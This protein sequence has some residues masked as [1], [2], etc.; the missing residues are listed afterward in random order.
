[1][2]RREEKLLFPVFFVGKR[3]KICYNKR[4][5]NMNGKKEEFLSALFGERTVEKTAGLSFSAA[6]ILPTLLALLFVIVGGAF[7][8]FQE[9]YETADWYQYFN[10]LLPQIGYAL[11]AALFFSLSRLPVKEITGNPSLKYFLIAALLQFGLFSLSELNA[12]FLQFLENF[13]YEN[14]PVQIPSLDGFGLL[15]VLFV[16]AALPAVFEEIVFRGIAL[17]GLKPFGTALS[18]TLCGAMFAIFHQNPAQTVYQFCCGA[19]FALLA[20]RSGSV[21]P[22]ALAHFLNNAVVILFAKFGSPVLPAPVSVALFVLSLVSLVLT[23]GYLLFF[24]KKQKP[25]R[26]KKR[27]LQFLLFASVG[28]LICLLS[29]FANFFGGI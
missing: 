22:T 3:E 13:G 2:D 20:L 15:G 17:R 16:V 7:G 28:L 5:K 4:M 14:T 21:F 12:L 8:L 23:V 6:V 26:D 27:G 25:E 29:W 19:A 11:V 1:M 10:F 24:D 9:G 18:V